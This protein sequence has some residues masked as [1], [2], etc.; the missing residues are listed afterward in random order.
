MHN[1]TRSIVENQVSI[2]FAFKLYVDAV[3]FAETAHEVKIFQLF[4]IFRGI[5]QLV[6]SVSSKARG[7]CAK[8]NIHS[9]EQFKRKMEEFRT[10]MEEL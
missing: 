10:F 7:S 4:Q 8:N 3:K 5:Y 1:F 6:L 2:S 9:F